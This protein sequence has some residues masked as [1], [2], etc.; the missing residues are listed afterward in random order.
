MIDAH[1]YT[2]KVGNKEIDFGFDGKSIVLFGGSYKVTFEKLLT[3]E[4]AMQDIEENYRIYED[5]DMSAF[6]RA[7]GF[8]D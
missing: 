2:M 8:Y 4:E 5:E 7:Y 1:E 6:Y 3:L